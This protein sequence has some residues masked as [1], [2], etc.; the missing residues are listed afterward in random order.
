VQNGRYRLE[1][2]VLV[3]LLKAVLRC[4][5]LLFAEETHLNPIS[6]AKVNELAIKYAL[7]VYGFH[8]LSKSGFLDE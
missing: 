7:A 2:E 4:D 8:V 6:I 5:I 3:L 1:R